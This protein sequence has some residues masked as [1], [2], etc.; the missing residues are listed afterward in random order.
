MIIFGRFKDRVTGYGYKK[1]A[2]FEAVT[3]RCFYYGS[4]GCCHR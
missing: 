2:H 1:I 4:K 3:D